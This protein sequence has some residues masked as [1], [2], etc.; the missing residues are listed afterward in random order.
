MPVSIN[1][2]IAPGTMTYG[3]PLTFGVASGLTLTMSGVMSGNATTPSDLYTVAAGKLVL[4]GTGTNAGGSTFTV[5]QGP[6]ILAMTA[7]VG[8]ARHRQ[9]QQQ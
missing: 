3:E 7:A 8:A 9:L 4:D 2:A 1:L 6:V 5:A